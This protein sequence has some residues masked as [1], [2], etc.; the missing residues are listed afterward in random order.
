MG[1]VGL[2]A[3]VLLAIELHNANVFGSTLVG[4]VGLTIQTVN[5]TTR[6]IDS[7]PASS[8]TFTCDQSDTLLNVQIGQYHYVGQCLPPR[9]R[10]KT[11][12]RGSVPQKV[13]LYATEVCQVDN[14][15]DTNTTTTVFVPSDSGGTFSLLNNGYSGA[16][17]RHEFQRF[18][19]VLHQASNI[20]GDDAWE[21]LFGQCDPYNT[22]TWGA[23]IALINTQLKA[24][25]AL[26]TQQQEW[27]T[28][29]DGFIWNQNKINTGLNQT[30]RR[31]SEALKLLSL[32]QSTLVEAQQALAR[33]ADELAEKQQG[34]LKFIYE[35]TVD[36]LAQLDAVTDSKLYA[37][38][39]K[40][41]NITRELNAH[42]DALIQ[43]TNEKE[44]VTDER[45]RAALRLI[46]RIQSDMYNGISGTN[47][48]ISSKQTRSVW[49]ALLHATSV[50][51]TPFLD[52]TNQG[53][54]PT[55]SL[56]DDD[57]TA[58]VEIHLINFVNLTQP[59]GGIPTIHSFQVAFYCN[60]AALVRVASTGG[61]WEDINDLIGP[62]GCANTTGSPV[63]AC[64]CWVEIQH[65][66]C[67]RPSGSTFTWDNV[68][69]T[70]DRNAYKLVSSMCLGNAQPTIDPVW[71]NR[72]I[73]SLSG[74]YGFLGALCQSKNMLGSTNFKVVPTRVTP[75]SVAANYSTSVCTVDL[76]DLFQRPGGAIT[77]N[78][79]YVLYSDWV[80][81]LNTMNTERDIYNRLV[82]GVLPRGLTSTF[83]PFK[84][85]ANKHAYPCY[86]MEM[87]TTTT[88][89]EIVYGLT[90][91]TTEP[92]IQI[93]VYD[94]PPDCTSSPGVCIPQGNHISSASTA[95]LTVTP[96][97]PNTLPANGDIIIGELD[98]FGLTEVYDIPK[99]LTS[100]APNEQS[101]RGLATYLL[102]PFQTGY[103]ITTT[104]INP[105][106]GDLNDWEADHPGSQFV[107]S[108]PISASYYKKTVTD[109]LVDQVP[110]IQSGPITNLLNK[111]I[112]DGTTNM[113]Q[114]VLALRPRDWSYTAT[115]QAVTGDIIITEAAGCPSRGYDPND[116]R[117]RALMLT[118]TKIF[119]IQVT[120]QRSSTDPTCGL[121]ADLTT[122]IS[123]SAIYTHIFPSCNN[124]TV[125]I[126]S[127]GTDLFQTLTQ[128]G[129]TIFSED[130][131]RTIQENV[132][133]SD[134]LNRTAIQISQELD[135][136]VAAIQLDIVQLL[137]QVFDTAFATNELNITVDELNGVGTSD[138]A[139]TISALRLRAA[140]IDYT[141]PNVTAT[142]VLA[143]YLSEVTGRQEVLT[144]TFV[145]LDQSLSDLAGLVEVSNIQAVALNDSFANLT[146]AFDNYIAVT[147]QVIRDLGIRQSTA[148]SQ[149]E[150][151]SRPFLSAITCTLMQFV[152]MALYVVLIGGV[153]YVAVWACKKGSSGSNKGVSGVPLYRQIKSRN[154]DT[155]D[156]Y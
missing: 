101:Q 21:C 47:L 149:V 120:L 25:E 77:I 15:Y 119:A 75:R 9:Y 98:A 111:M 31:T 125:T 90:P 138:L 26:A 84:V 100:F 40:F 129:E 130:S 117:G 2:F 93:D 108:A 33:H 112:V 49:Q 52:P 151:S 48:F 30:L 27:N 82:L 114:G 150:C 28:G 153:V 147:D 38:Q 44:E 96:P 18:G 106:M 80:I 123:P 37:L 109:G 131:Q 132:L 127:V 105:V 155:Y 156:Y 124:Y 12:A 58:F 29:V 1:I 34:D 51:R 103:D 36:G 72:R 5:E 67:A 87:A 135:R 55:T 140:G 61:T 54:A 68:T 141:S 136:N 10:Y 8:L 66:S 53:V 139:L 91:D 4:R 148:S 32:Q 42:I 64:K 102:L 19:R 95:S 20:G 134:L 13:W 116:V 79:P 23:D 83:T 154:S 17:P 74:L 46:R 115:I 99:D 43:H 92:F 16:H 50:G 104:S 86:S 69:T 57:R 73:D 133:S 89:T 78:L 113:R 128:C 142:A 118:N 97:A 137:L 94:Q 41:V 76:Y 22:N 63:R 70:S 7:Y 121:L 81:G 14:S 6:Q 11:T 85:L 3:L 60:I 56:S 62:V 144:S 45:I 107:H 59:I 126:Y 71:N 152:T 122:T 146:R 24:A 145:V 143:P 65:T 35:Q 88:E 110:G 39:I